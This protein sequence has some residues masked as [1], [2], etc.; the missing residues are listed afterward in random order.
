MFTIISKELLAFKKDK[1]ALMLTFIVPMLLIT[2]F[3]LAFGGAGKNTGID[4]INLLVVDEDHSPISEQALLAIDSVKMLN[5]IRATNDSA[6]QLIHT[7]KLSAALVIHKGFQDSVNALKSLPWELEYDAAQMQETGILQQLLGQGLY[8]N[9]G[10]AMSQ[11]M[12]MRSIKSQFGG[13]MDSATQATLFAQV[14]NNVNKSNKDME[15][16]QQNKMQLKLTSVVKSSQDNVGIVQAVA[17]TAVMMLLFSITAMG[18]RILDE[19]ENGTLKRLLYSPLHFNQILMGKMATSVIVASCQLMVMLIYAAMVLGLHLWDKLP[20]VFVLVM[21]IACA[22]SGFGV[23]L[24]SLAKSR[25]QLQ[26]LSTLTV[27]SMSAIGGSMIPTFM[28]PHWMQSISPFSI[29][30]WSIQGFYDVFWRQLPFGFEFLKKVG[31][32]LAIGGVLS[33]LSFRFFRKNVLSLV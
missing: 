3:A 26:G 33:T 30:Y 23:F 2:I 9:V 5:A 12:V 13:N 29:N 17:G 10:K 11:K 27:L 14:S 25:E 4:R 19:K 16:L 24:A 21:G 8:G 32:L 28:M 6:L 20:M 31:I 15:D 1:R 22:C 7:G 18:G